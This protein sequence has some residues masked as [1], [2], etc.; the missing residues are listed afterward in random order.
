MKRR[1]PRS[2]RTDTLWPYTARFRSSGRCPDR[3]STVPSPHLRRPRLSESTLPVVL[4]MI[5]SGT[6]ML[7]PAT[8][9]ARCAETIHART[10]DALYR[11]HHR[12]LVFSLRARLPSHQDAEELPQNA[13]ARLPPPHHTPS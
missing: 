9:G 11:S 2:T 1:P 13:F 12:P 3:R 10:V 8:D 4:E 7:D 6:P 5:L